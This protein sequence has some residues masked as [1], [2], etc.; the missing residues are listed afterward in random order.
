M[1]ITRDSLTELQRDLLHVTLNNGG[2]TR[3]RGGY[4]ATPGAK[5]FTVR[6]VMALQRMALLTLSNGTSQV[7]ITAQGSK[8]ILTGQVEIAEK[9]SV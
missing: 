8:V 4:V 2:L 6:T 5:P 1:L 9:S 3:A 7:A